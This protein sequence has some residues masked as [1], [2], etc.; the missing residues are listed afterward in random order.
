LPNRPPQGAS[1]E[2]NNSRNSPLQTLQ[3]DLDSVV[4]EELLDEI[5][6]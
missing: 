1:A 6:R 3:P 5:A 2:R 4:A